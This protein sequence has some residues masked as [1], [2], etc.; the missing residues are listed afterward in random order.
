MSVTA[1]ELVSAIQGINS[2][3]FV[4]QSVDDTFLASSNN[5]RYKCS[6]TRWYAGH[7]LTIN[8][9]ADANVSGGK[10]T[11]I[12]STGWNYSWTTWWPTFDAVVTGNSSASIQGGG[13]R[14][15]VR[16]DGQVKYWFAGIPISTKAINLSCVKNA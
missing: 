4:S 9:W 5:K 2:A 7:G 13:S 6:A 16:F 3:S 12:T 11:E 14:I 1:S 15:K 10:I 8:Y